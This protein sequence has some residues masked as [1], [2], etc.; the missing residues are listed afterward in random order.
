MPDLSSNDLT[1]YQKYTHYLVV[2]IKAEFLQ[3][4]LTLSVII[5]NI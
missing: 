4:I 5:F 1:L 3:H 2:I